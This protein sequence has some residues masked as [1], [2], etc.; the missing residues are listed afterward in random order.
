MPLVPGHDTCYSLVLKFYYIFKIV[1]F[2]MGLFLVVKL[3]FIFVF[4]IFHGVSSCDLDTMVSRN[5]KKPISVKALG[6]CSP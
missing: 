6:L 1:S 5:E 4:P 2:Q 3:H